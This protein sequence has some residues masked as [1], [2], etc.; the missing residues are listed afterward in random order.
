MNSIIAM[1]F[2]GDVLAKSLVMTEI[3]KAPIKYLPKIRETITSL[4]NNR[5]NIAIELMCGNTGKE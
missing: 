4:N 2:E 3:D 5:N 1:S